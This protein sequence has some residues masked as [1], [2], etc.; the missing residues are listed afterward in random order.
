MGATKLKIF[1][2]SEKEIALIG[3]AIAHPAR[4]RILHLLKDKPY[5]RNVDLIKDLELCKKT[6]YDHLKKL[7]DAGLV[8]SDFFWNS[9]FVSRTEGVE[10]ILVKFLTD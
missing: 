7:E 1:T 10:E 9:Y 5:V 2:P 8:K 3:R 4:V 6:V